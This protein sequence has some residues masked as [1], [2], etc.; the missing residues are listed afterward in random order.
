MQ[1]MSP[2]DATF[3]YVEDGVTHMHIASCAVFE[4]PAP[5]YEQVVATI[6]GKLTKIP[7]YRQV[8]RFVPLQLGRPVW[9]DDPH[10]R[11]EYHVRH[12][13]LPP[14]GGDTELRALMGRLMSQELDRHRPLWETWMIEGLERG[15]W[16]LITKIH[17]CMADGVAGTDLLAVILDREPDPP[18]PEADL[19]EPAAEPSDLDLVTDAVVALARNPYEQLR[20][21]RRATRAPRRTFTRLQE[22]AAG[23]KSYAGQMVPTRTNSLVGA[24]GPNRRWTWVTAD[25]AD[26]KTIRS[27]F[28]GTVNDVI[29]SVVTG[30]LRELLIARGEPIEELVVRSLIPVSIRSEDTREIVDNRVSAMFA[31]L[32]VAVEDPIERLAA[33]RSQMDMLK[34]S[35][36]TDAGIGLTVLGEFAPSAAVALAERTVMQVLRRM[37]QH[38][39][40]MVVTNIPGPQH[41]LYLAGREMLQ[42]LP[43]VPIAHGVRVGVAIVSYNGGLFFGITGD[44]DTT[45]DIDV[46]AHG[47]ED[48][49]A[50]LIGLAA[51]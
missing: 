49:I 12:T 30:G 10:F 25:L 45:P 29:V 15:R 27:A 4:G 47:I 46:V 39:V 26:A 13:A 14:P 35:H 16:G 17:H 43:F 37:P 31:D 33:V 6:A 21:L 7:R 8:V 9:V 5:D 18:P 42:Y 28:G 32:P 41:P 23:M 38:S 36:Q 44:Y 40:N 34:G 51:C 11:L 3:L 24:I 1:R 20:A 48:A 19:W 22:M 50:Q 2:L